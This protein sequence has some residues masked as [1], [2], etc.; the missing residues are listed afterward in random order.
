MKLIHGY[1]SH[2]TLGFPGVVLKWHSD[3]FDRHTGPYVTVRGVMH[4]WCWRDGV[5]SLSKS[6]LEPELKRFEEHVRLIYVND[7]TVQG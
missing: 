7:A 1:W 2:T 6:Q 4:S 3:E 5:V